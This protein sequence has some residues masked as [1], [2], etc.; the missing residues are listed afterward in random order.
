MSPR[1][2][3]PVLRDCGIPAGSPAAAAHAV[4]TLHLSGTLQGRKPPWHNKNA[5][6]FGAP[7]CQLFF[8]SETEGATR[9]KVFRD[10][11]VVGKRHRG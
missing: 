9:L 11:L 7:Y 3:H 1:S 5:W 2:Q 4:A 6:R 8:R 10:G